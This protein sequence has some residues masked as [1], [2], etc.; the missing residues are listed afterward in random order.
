[1]RRVDF[2]ILLE[3]AARELDVATALAHVL[4]RRHGL[5]TEIVQQYEARAT[6]FGR[7]RPSVVVLPYAYH[8][9][10]NNHYLL[11]WRD[12]A[13]FSLTWEQLF[14]PGV[15]LAKSPRGEFAL[16]HVIHHAWSDAYADHL[17][18]SGV[19]EQHI[20]VGGHPAYALYQEPYRRYFKPRAQIAQEY[21]LDPAR[22]WVFLPEN[23]NWAFYDDAM[24]A[25][26]IRSGQPADQVAA[27]R[28]VVTASF[29]A[30]MRWCAALAQRQD[31]ELIIRPRPATSPELFRRRVEEVVGT[32]P[33]R[34]SVSVRETVREWILASDVVISSYSTSLIEAAIAGRPSFILEPVP[35]PES[36]HNP[37]HGLLPHLCSEGALM[38]AVDAPPGDGNS[39]LA[40]WAQTTLM[41]RGD[42]IVRIADELARILAR[43]VPIPEPPPW[44]SIAPEARFGM[45]RRLL[46]ELRRRFPTSVWPAFR[47]VDPM[48]VQDVAAVREVPDRVR[49]WGPILDTYLASIPMRVA[50]QV[51]E[52]AL[53]PEDRHQH[54][55]QA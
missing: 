45:P 11:R 12:A 52:P 35:W 49:R 4:S 14:Y 8:Q 51:S 21:G 55:V 20:F 32:L 40:Q 10:Y 28:D 34:M 6:I 44:W 27:M 41:G 37:W 30:A 50:N 7:I 39:P 15:A 31:V 33:P 13:F 46:Y 22:R 5:T 1:M 2:C 48:L 3:R 26:L 24:L 47:R 29:E 36:L 42:P 54:N 43:S 19:P 23:Y 17:R 53:A 16:R 25:E 18:A 38:A 9:R